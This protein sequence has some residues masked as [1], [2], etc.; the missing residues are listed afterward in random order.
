MLLIHQVISVWLLLNYNPDMIVHEMW[1]CTSKLIYGF[2]YNMFMCYELENP[3]FRQYLKDIAWIFEFCTGVSQKNFYIR[4]LNF[5]RQVQKSP[6]DL[7]T[8]K[9]KLQRLVCLSVPSQLYE[10]NRSY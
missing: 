2:V 9:I 3:E 1:Q 10:P 6:V 7:V 8:L 4:E 5:G